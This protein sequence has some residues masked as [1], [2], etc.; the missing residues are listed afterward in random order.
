M[1]D[2]E[3]HKLKRS[4]LLEMLLEQSRVIDRLKEQLEAAEKKLQAREILLDEAGSI[5]EASIMIT[6][7][8][9]EAQKAADCYLENVR[10]ICEQE[11]KKKDL[12]DTDE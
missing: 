12:G 4:E 7:V 10:R 5:A 1:T 6:D 9:S 11:S 8:F 2:K 3:L